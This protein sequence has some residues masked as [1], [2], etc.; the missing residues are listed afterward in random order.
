VLILVD[1]DGPLANFEEDFLKKWRRRFPDFDYIPLEERNTF[2][3]QEQHPACFKH[4]I[5]DIFKA[6]EF[7]LNLPPIEGAIEAIAQMIDMGHEVKICTSPLPAFENCVL[8]KYK[9]VERHLGR[10]LTEHIILTKDKTLVRGDVLIDDK[11]EIEGTLTPTWEHVLFDYPFNREVPNKKR[12]SNRWDNWLE[13]INEIE[14][15]KKS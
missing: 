9:W 3:V 12:I 6:P 15:N 11:P 10:E 2:Y 5:E 1:Q 13:V 4:V 14:E 8:E 7:F